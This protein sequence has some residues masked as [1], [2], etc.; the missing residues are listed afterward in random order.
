VI[1]AVDPRVVDAVARQ[2][3]APP[4]MAADALSGRGVRLGGRKGAAAAGLSRGRRADD[5]RA[6]WS[7]FARTLPAGLS[8]RAIAE[9]VAARFGVRPETVRK[10]L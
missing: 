1:G 8:Q 9:R 3:V 7:T 6:E 2:V 4:G 10:A 5:Q